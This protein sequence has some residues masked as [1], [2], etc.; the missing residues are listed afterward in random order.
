MA[1]VLYRENGANCH[2][3]HYPKNASETFTFNDLVYIDANGD[4]TKYTTNAGTILGQVLKTVAAT[5][6]DYASTTKTPVLVCGAEAEYLCD[7]STG[8]AAITNVGDY[9]DTD[10]HNSV[11]VDASTHDEFYVTQM[12]STTQVVAKMTQRL[13]GV[14]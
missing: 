8:T 13:P 12:V 7:V 2:V 6:S 4:F 1:I 10:D 11:D 14:H 9:I 5:D 3:E